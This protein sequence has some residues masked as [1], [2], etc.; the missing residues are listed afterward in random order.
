MTYYL[1]CDLT[2]NHPTC[3]DGKPYYRPIGLVTNE[4]MAYRLGADKVFVMDD[5]EEAKRLFVK[6]HVDVD[7][8]ET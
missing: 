3:V 1:P 7:Y 6:K 8:K 2:K 4:R 5:Y